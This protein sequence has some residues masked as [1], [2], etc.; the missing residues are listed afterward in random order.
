M[1]IPIPNTEYIL[2]PNVILVVG[3]IVSF[4]FS[5]GIGAN[6][7]ANTLSTAVGSGAISLHFAVILGGFMEFAGAVLM[8]GKVSDTIRK[9]IVDPNSFTNYYN[10]MGGMLA[11]LMGGT[12]WLLLAIIFRLPVSTTHAVIGGVSGFAIIAVGVSSIVWNKIGLIA[13]SWLLSPIV[14]GVFSALIYWIMDKTWMSTKMKLTNALVWM[15]SFIFVTSV[16]YCVFIMYKVFPVTISF[17]MALL[18]SIAL[19][20]FVSLFYIYIVRKQQY[21]RFAAELLEE[22]KEAQNPCKQTKEEPEETV[23]IDFDIDFSS[24]VDFNSDLKFESFIDFNIDPDFE[25]VDYS[26]PHQFEIASPKQKDMI[27]DNIEDNVAENSKLNFV[28]TYLNDDEIAKLNE[29]IGHVHEDDIVS[30][31]DSVDPSIDGF[32]DGDVESPFNTS[33]SSSVWTDQESDDEDVDENTKKHVAFEAIFIPLQL[34]TSLSL[35]FAHGSN[36]TANSTGPMTAIIACWESMSVESNAVVPLWVMV[37]GGFGIVCGLS[38]LGHKVIAIV[39][40]NIT[41]ISPSIG[42]VVQ[43]SASIVVLLG[44]SFGLPLSTTH[45]LIGCIVGIGLIRKGIEGV[46]WKIV[47]NIGV[48]W[49]VTLS[50]AGSTTAIFF[51]LLQLGMGSERS[52]IL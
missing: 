5:F 26:S 19:S 1:G 15:P 38:V 18:I 47:V 52:W 24:P 28:E 48:S 3:V 30:Y 7:V 13:A 6:D 14:G 33:K 23:C 46:K 40:S 39:G 21:I 2:T 20:I 29:Q 35:A 32:I 45:T 17:T 12:L 37:L 8:G 41:E 25:L 51:K 11:T 31:E 36:D 4:A 34:A 9:D 50:V 44:S 27:E 42:F 43:L 16:I 49:I 10:F 22:R